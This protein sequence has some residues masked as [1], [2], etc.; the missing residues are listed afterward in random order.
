VRLG[1]CWIDEP[2]ASARP[3]ES[4]AQAAHTEH[5]TDPLWAAVDD[6]WTSKLN[7]P[8]PALDAAAAESAT[9]G[10][11]PIAVTPATGKMLQ[12]LARTVNARRI[13]EI[14]T[15][16]GYSTIWLARALPPD[17]E[18]V[19]CEIDQ[20][21]ADVAAANLARA[22]VEKVVDIRVGRARDTLASL[23]GP[24]D[25]A[26]VDADK[27]SGAE[28][29]HECLRLVRSGGL[30]VVDNVVR[31]GKIVDAGSTDAA[32]M[33]TWRLADAVAAEP[34]VDATVIQT[35]SGKEYDGYLLA[36][37]Q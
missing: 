30:I 1:T 4:P 36:R 18:L 2:A 22:E 32:V 33:G 27:A 7:S 14:G 29:F 9:A 5:V 19:T 31:Q 28:Y 13:L 8:D 24:F 21:H 17:G 37:V 12:L 26:F 15:L 10:L 11:P 20:N 3:H 16:G 34:R 35:V 25:F 6:Y 23:E